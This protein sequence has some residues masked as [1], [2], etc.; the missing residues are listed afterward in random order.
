MGARAPSP[1][2]PSP[3]TTFERQLGGALPGVKLAGAASGGVRGLL[4]ASA[5]VAMLFKDDRV[6]A[7][8]VVEVYVDEEDVGWIKFTPW[9]CGFTAQVRV[10][11]VKAASVIVAAPF[12]AMQAVCKRQRR[13]WNR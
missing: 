11:D 5:E 13:E 2:P 8:R 9:G 6:C 10:D 1:H 12:D 3:S 4:A 7:V